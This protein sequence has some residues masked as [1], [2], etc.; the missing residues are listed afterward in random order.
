MKAHGYIADLA[1]ILRDAEKP[2]ALEAIATSHVYI[3]F[4]TFDAFV[5]ACQYT[6]TTKQI[7]DS[8]RKRLKILLDMFK[9]VH[10]MD[11]VPQLVDVF[12]PSS[13]RR[14][15][16][17]NNSYGSTIVLEAMPQVCFKNSIRRMPTRLQPIHWSTGHHGHS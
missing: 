7:R 5:A 13:A 2:W 12:G 10:G 8:V 9:D 16:L 17:S 15:L 3:P 1:D 14:I 6:G 4:Q 11:Y